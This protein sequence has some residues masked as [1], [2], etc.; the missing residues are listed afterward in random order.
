MSYEAYLAVLERLDEAVRR[1]EVHPDF[2]T[3]ARVVALLGDIDTAH[4][5][6]LRR[7]VEGLR[8]AGAGE[9]LERVTAD[10]VVR[11]LLG[12]YDLADLGLPEPGRSPA[13]FVPLAQ[14][15]RRSTAD[16]A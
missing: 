6:G 10:R 15:K 9:A 11:T 5:E 7:L 8:E 3:R 13:G 1:F 12:L 2:P 14:L 16:P 4:R